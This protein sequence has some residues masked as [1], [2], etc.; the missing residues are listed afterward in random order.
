MSRAEKRLGEM[1]VTLPNLPTLIANDVI[2]KRAGNLVFTASQVSAVEERAYKGKPG[3]T[4]SIEDGRA[5]P[6][7]CVITCLAALKSVVGSL[8]HFKQIVAVHGLVNSTDGI[9]SPEWE[10]RQRWYGFHEK[11]DA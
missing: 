6:R 1:E 5:A 9:D 8:D 2:A 10:R 3:A 11:E 7:A 4:V